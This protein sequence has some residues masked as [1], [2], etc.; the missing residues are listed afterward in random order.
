M[1]IALSVELQEAVNRCAAKRG[2]TKSTLFQELINK[3]VIPSK[4][5]QTV[6]L[7]VPFN[8]KDKPEELRDWL[9]ARSEVI[10]KSF[11]TEQPPE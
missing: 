4:D 5:Y 7:R 1:S 6:V 11:S 10:I 3:Y 9:N 2:I 8:L